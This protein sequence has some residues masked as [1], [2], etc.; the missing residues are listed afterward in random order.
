MKRTVLVFG[1]FDLLHRGHRSFLRQAKKLGTTLIVA[2][3]RDRN[4]RKLKGRR[5]ANNER[6]RRDAVAELPYVERAV[7][8]PA[9]PSR[10]FEFIKRIGPEIIALGYDQTHYTG[11]LA[12]ALRTRGVRLKIVRLKPFLPSRYKTSLLRKTLAPLEAKRKE[13]RLSS[14]R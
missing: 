12:Q 1:T 13:R 8:A 3:S 7:L 5:T 6:K 4:V 9:D 2:V 10:R 14:F 11:N